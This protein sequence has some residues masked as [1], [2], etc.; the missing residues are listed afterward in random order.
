MTLLT[1]IMISSGVIGTSLCCA[2]L[3]HQ[4][5]KRGNWIPPKPAP[6]PAIASD[7]NWFAEREADLRARAT[8]R[9][10]VWDAIAKMDVQSF[11]TS[12]RNKDGW[13]IVRAHIAVYSMCGC[14]IMLEMTNGTKFTLSVKDYID[15][16]MSDEFAKTRASYAIPM[17]RRIAEQAAFHKIMYPHH[18]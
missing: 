14:Y 8:R 3:I 1:D 5:N 17:T 11:K 4:A 10:L 13:H 15:Y 16:Y 18:D 9:Q 7:S 12:I 2:Y 6:E